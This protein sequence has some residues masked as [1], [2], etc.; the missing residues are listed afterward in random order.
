VVILSESLGR[1][2]F[3]ADRPVGR[4]FPGD[5]ENN[6]VVGNRSASFRLPY[7]V[8][9]RFR[10]RFQPLCCGQAERRV[11]G[12]SQ[13]AGRRRVKLGAAAEAAG[14]DQVVQARFPALAGSDWS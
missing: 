1:S 6:Q 13:L 8:A 14:R 11:L 7:Y 2:R 10:S 3:D 12:P 4:R 9:R 5:G